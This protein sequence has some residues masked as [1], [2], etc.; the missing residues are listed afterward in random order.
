MNSRFLIIF[1][2][3]FAS[4]QIFAM[5]VPQTVDVKAGDTA[6]LIN[7][8]NEANV[9]TGANI[10]FIV[11]GDNDET[12]FVFSEPAAGFDSAL[13]DITSKISFFGSSGVNP[14][15]RTTIDATGMF[16]LFKVTGD[17]GEADVILSGFTIDGFWNF[18][19]RWRCH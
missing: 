6:G 14:A 3:A 11:K 9:G 17:M 2:C 1:F 5:D 7:A 4:S 12:E 15:F 16:R 13:P 19:R 10:I 18:A 8:I